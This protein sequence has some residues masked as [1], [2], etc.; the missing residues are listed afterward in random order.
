[1]QHNQTQTDIVN[2]RK[3]EQQA[4][5]KQREEKILFVCSKQFSGVN[6]IYLGKFL[7]EICLWAK[8]EEGD[9]N[10]DPQSVVYEKARR[11]VWKILRKFI[12]AKTLADI[13][14]FDN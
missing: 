7:A 12:P 14:I 10:V 3:E 9:I 11:D 13:E 4:I 2:S 5:Q 8:Y 6:G 1:M